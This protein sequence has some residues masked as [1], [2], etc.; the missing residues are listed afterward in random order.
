MCN[1][2]TWPQRYSEKLVLKLAPRT[3]KNLRHVQRIGTFWKKSHRSHIESA[4]FHF[5]FLTS[6]MY[7]FFE[8]RVV[9][10]RNV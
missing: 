8:K 6:L 9:K 7:K 3:E 1:R 10:K 2:R 5:F 4:N